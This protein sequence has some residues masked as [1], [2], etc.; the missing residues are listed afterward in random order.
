[1]A[2]HTIRIERRFAAPQEVVFEA[3]A[4]VA[5]AADR[6]ESIRRIELLTEGPI[7]VGTRWR[8]TRRMFGKDAT[9]EMEITAY[10]PPTDLTVRAN[11]HGTDYV[12]VFRFEAADGGT[13]LTE[14]FTATMAEPN[15]FQRVMW[16]VFGSVGARMTKKMMVTEL[17][18]VDRW[19]HRQSAGNAER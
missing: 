14:E 9:E 17:D 3:I 8:E 18:D 12:T 16:L 4:N 15:L 2:G 13:R 5:E 6:V 19:I 10:E 7:G 11:S 1:M